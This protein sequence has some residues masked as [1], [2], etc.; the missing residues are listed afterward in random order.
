MIIYAII[1][2]CLQLEVCWKINVCIMMVQRLFQWQHLLW[3]Q[4]KIISKIS[5]FLE[6][7]KKA[8]LWWWTQITLINKALFLNDQNKF[9]GQKLLQTTVHT[10]TWQQEILHWRCVLTTRDVPQC[11]QG[12]MHRKWNAKH[13]FWKM[14]LKMHLLN[15]VENKIQISWKSTEFIQ[16]TTSKHSSLLSFHRYF[17]FFKC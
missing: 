5:S 6:V 12:R 13:M 3:P 17:S 9:F 10:C 14:S 2:V 1:K 7:T 11:P 8:I 16:W 4:G 15:L